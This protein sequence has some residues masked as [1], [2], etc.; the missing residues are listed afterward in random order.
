MGT[1]VGTGKEHP[2]AAEKRLTEAA[3]KAAKP[4]DKVYYLNDGAGLRLRVRESGIRTWVFRYRLNNKELSAGLGVY[5]AVSLQSARIKAQE[6]Y[7]LDPLKT[8]THRGQ[9]LVRQMDPEAFKKAC[10]KTQVPLRRLE[11][12]TRCFCYAP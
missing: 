1:G 10:S 9:T 5:P 2:M 11:S 7:C 6:L 8:S 12:F 4:R 3:C